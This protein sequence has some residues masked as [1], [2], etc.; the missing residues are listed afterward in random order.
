MH[1]FANAQLPVKKNGF[2]SLSIEQAS[3]STAAPVVRILSGFLEAGAVQTKL[4]EKLSEL[5]ALGRIVAI[6]EVSA[7]IVMALQLHLD[8]KLFQ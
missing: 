3:L 7:R 4:T 8:F 1:A 2:W 6:A 5:A